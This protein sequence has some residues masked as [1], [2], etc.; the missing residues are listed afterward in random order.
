MRRM[1]R[2]TLEVSTTTLLEHF[3]H[4]LPKS[5]DTWDIISHLLAHVSAASQK[6]L[7][8]NVHGTLVCMQLSIVKPLAKHLI[9][10]HKSH[11][12][13]IKIPPVTRFYIKL[14]FHAHASPY[15]IYHP[16]TPILQGTNPHNM[17]AY[18]THN[19]S[20]NKQQ[21]LITDMHIPPFPLLR[22]VHRV[23]NIIHAPPILLTHIAPQSHSTCAY[24]AA[25]L[26][27]P[28]RYHVV[29][30]NEN[31]DILLMC[32][33]FPNENL[34]QRKVHGRMYL[35]ALWCWGYTETCTCVAM[36][37]RLDEY[38]D[39]RVGGGNLVRT[40]L[41]CFACARIGCIKFHAL[42]RP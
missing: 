16:Q 1:F 5:R 23:Q 41:L 24:I 11:I 3:I 6:A 39:M 18:T 21:I 42:Y 14:P 20:N 32:Y 38:L 9:E 36:C 7:F 29:Y 26:Y 2:C 15:S 40:S 4:V 17:H 22:Q 37:A 30:G 25:L 31:G 35:L 10:Y 34:K 12:L 19:P 33:D 27:I 13:S 28:P 8:D